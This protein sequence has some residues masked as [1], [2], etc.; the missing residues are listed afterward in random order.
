LS[1]DQSLIA[2][3]TLHSGND[4]EATLVGDTTGHSAF[5]FK[6]IMRQSVP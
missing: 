6:S 2:G 5:S 1:R 3:A 4:N